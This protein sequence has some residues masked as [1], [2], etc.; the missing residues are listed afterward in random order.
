MAKSTKKKPAPVA[1]EAEVDASQVIGAMREFNNEDSER[2]SDAG[3]SRQRIGAFLEQTKLNAK[4]FSH[5]RMGLR[6]KKESNRLDWLRSLKM[7]LPM[8]E[9]ED[10]PLV[11]DIAPCAYHH[12]KAAFAKT[13]LFSLYAEIRG[14]EDSSSADE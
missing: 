5:L 14:A 4:A 3:E 7:M 13:L 2:A 9:A 10:A 12:V 6:I 1:V 8:I 11:G